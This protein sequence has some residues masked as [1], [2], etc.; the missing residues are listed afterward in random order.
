MQVIWS[1]AAQVKSSCQCSSCLYSVV[2]LT[3]RSTTVAVKRRKL[4]VGELFTACYSS[5]L[6][7]AAI[8]DAKAKDSRI[9]DWDRAIA[10]V[11]SGK[12]IEELK[13]PGVAQKRRTIDYDVK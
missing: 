8:A 13:V 2:A 1:R 11:K 5:I 3:R 6:A 12:P 7:S 4:T 10:D 9:R